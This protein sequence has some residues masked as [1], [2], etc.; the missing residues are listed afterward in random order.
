MKKL[1]TILAVLLPLCIYAQDSEYSVS[2]YLEKGVKAPNTHHIGEAWLNFLLKAD[3]HFDQNITQATFSPNST[4]DWHKHATPQVIIVLDGVGYY[5]ER[6][7][8]PVVM[9]KGDVIKCE[10]DTEHWHTSSADNGVSYIAI[11]GKEPTIWTEKLTREY[12]DS[13]AE[14]LRDN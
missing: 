5:Q 10:K 12:Y 1:T 13:V 9:K 3:N 8:E 14:K 11:Y 6:D 7:K 2:S 4:L